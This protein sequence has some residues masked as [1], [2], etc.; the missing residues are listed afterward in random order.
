VFKHEQNLYETEG[1]D[2]N[3]IKFPDNSDVLNL[4]E[5]R[6]VGVFAICD[7]QV[8]FPKATDITLIHKLYEK[9]SSHSRFFAGSKEKADNVFVVKHFAG[10]VKYSSISFLEKNQDVV[11]PELA[12]VANNSMSSLVC[13]L[14]DFFRIDDALLNKSNPLAVRKQSSRNIQSIKAVQSTANRL[15]LHNRTKTL[16]GE[17]RGQMEELMTNINTTSPHYIRCLKPNSNNIGNE[18]DSPLIVSQLRCG[19]VL[20]AVRVS[21]AGYSKRFTFDVFYRRYCFYIG[22]RCPTSQSFS[23]ASSKILAGKIAA[24]ALSDTTFVPSDDSIGQT[25]DLRL[26]GIQVGTTSVFF[27]SHTFDFMERQ[28]LLYHRGQAVKI[29]ASARKYNAVRTFRSIKDAAGVIQSS[30][31]IYLAKKEAYRLK[32]FASIMML[33]RVGR[34][35]LARRSFRKMINGFRRLQIVCRA[36]VEKRRTRALQKFTRAAIII[37]CFLRRRWAFRELRQLRID[38]RNVDKVCVLSCT[39]YFFIIPYTMVFFL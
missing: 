19:G 21:R 39:W 14:A 6:I 23:Q 31:R 16:G 22:E 12:N 25:D 2:W 7:E 4:L 35:F 27:R 9:C 30:T 20:E 36:G 17:F 38:A 18:F 11:R 1:I 37:Q 26:I 29:Q 13:D 34:G 5:D 10:P 8:R 32:T 3:F 24:K 33:Q 28:K 15:S